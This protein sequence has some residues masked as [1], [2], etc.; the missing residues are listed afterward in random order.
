LNS[1]TVE[2]RGDGAKGPKASGLLC[3]NGV[4]YL[5]ARNTGNAQLAWSDD[6]GATWTWADW[7]LSASFGCPTFLNC[8]RDYA[9]ASDDYVYV[10]SLDGNSA[11][12]AADQMVL[13]RVPKD[14]I[15]KYSAWE[16]FA[17]LDAQNQPVWSSDIA[18]R[19]AVFAHPGRCYRSGITYNAALKRFLW[20]QVFPQS[21]HPQGPRF[22]GGFGVFDAPAPWGPWTRVF[23]TEN[24]DVGPGETASLPS[25]WISADGRTV[26]L[27][28]SGDDHFSV[29]QG[30]LELMAPSTS[31]LR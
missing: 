14:R 30:T 7:K 31:T 22:Q 10:Y 18:R 28:F 20:V 11:Y 29:R 3:V 13:A 8:G 19:G 24:W 4:L 12:E 23:V 15:R 1:P 21:R 16:F 2:A 17:R 25:K 5:L 9:G 27:V 6:H 26:H